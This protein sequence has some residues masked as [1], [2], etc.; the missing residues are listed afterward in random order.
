MLKI[1]DFSKL[2]RVSVRMLRYYDEIGLIHPSSTDMMTGYRYYEPGQLIDIGRI[3]ALRE[4]GFG[5]A[6]IGT[7]INAPDPALLEEAL[8]R[9]QKE[10]ESE[11][12]QAA[13]RLTL[14]ESTLKRLKKD[15]MTM[16]FDVNLKTIP[17]RYAATIRNVIPSYEQESLLWST[18]MNETA[19][20]KLT[21]D[22]PCYCCAVFHDPEFKETDVDVEVQQTLQGAYPDTE[23]VKFR[24][25]PAVTVAATVVRGSYALLDEAYAAVAA[26][27]TDNGYVL[28][29]PLFNIYHV[30]PHETR[31]PDEFVTEVCYPV[32]KV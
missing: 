21:Y 4:M 14:L 28:N 9:R 23:H 18:L 17:E 11:A 12:R 24:T 2:S 29:G 1:G 8:L 6:E 27:L 3:T 20:M 5:L 7:L 10:L 25:L 31:N 13:Y 16:K 19:D 15:V 26:W 22:N 32:R 30:S